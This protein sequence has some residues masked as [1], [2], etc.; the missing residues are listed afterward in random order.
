M[1]KL[2]WTLGL[3]LFSSPLTFAQ[4]IPQAQDDHD[5]FGP[6]Q[7]GYAVVTPSTP[8]VATGLVVT[9]FLGLRRFAETI[10]ASTTPPPLI[11]SATMFVDINTRLLK[12]LGVA[13][14]NPGNGSTDVTLTVR[15]NDN[16]VLGTK[17]ITIATRRQVL[18]FVSEMFS[19]PPGSIFSTTSTLPAEFTGTLIINSTLPISV[20]G[21]RFRG[22]DFTAMPLNPV[23]VFTQPLPTI[24]LGVGGLGAVLL[25][26]FAA[27]GG[28]A[29]EIVISNT[30]TTSATVRVDF[31]KQDGTPLTTAL[32]GQTGSSFTNLTIVAGGVLVLA[33]RNRAGDDDF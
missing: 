29:T 17:T 16:L 2:F 21:M 6:T 14:V 13:I 31:F 26:Q 3:I 8:N 30:N 24:S 7:V 25:P 1:T 12:D 27:G 23:T 33:P 32:N 9:E 15:R 18:Q 4:G 20:F 22:I 5:D 10:Q 19:I 11:T 28:W